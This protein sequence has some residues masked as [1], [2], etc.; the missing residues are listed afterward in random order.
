M[1]RFLY[2]LYSLY[3]TNNFTMKLKFKKYLV[4]F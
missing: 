2:D 3:I 4:N 1:Y